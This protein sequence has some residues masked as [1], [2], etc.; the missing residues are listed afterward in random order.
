TSGAHWRKSAANVVPPETATRGPARYSR[1]LAATW[2]R[3]SSTMTCMCSFRG[4]RKDRRRFWFSGKPD[5][6]IPGPAPGYARCSVHR[7]EDFFHGAERRLGGRQFRKAGV[8]VVHA[9]RA[10]E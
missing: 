8:R 9:R 7:L 10:V 2:S 4:G 5:I 3:V 1:D 6:R